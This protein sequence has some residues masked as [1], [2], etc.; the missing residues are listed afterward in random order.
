MKTY[1]DGSFEQYTEMHQAD[2][3]NI[4]STI[5]GGNVCGKCGLRIAYSEESGERF[6]S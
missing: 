3:S 2:G 6:N 1:F 5:V 4:R